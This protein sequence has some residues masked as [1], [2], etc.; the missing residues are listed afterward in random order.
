MLKLYDYFRS[1]CAY[2]VR[3]ALNIKAVEYETISI[4]LL[5]GKHKAQDY[6]KVNPQGLVPALQIDDTTLLTQ[7][8]AILDWINERYEVPPLFSQDINIRAAQRSVCSLIA[9]DI[10]PL[11]NLRVL[12]YLS[13][14]LSVNEADKKIWYQHWVQSAFQVIEEAIKEGPFSFGKTVSMVDIYLVPQVYNALRFDCDMSSFSNIMRVYERCNS[15]PEFE[16][17]HPDNA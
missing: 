15:R 9:C 10:H 14:E 5:N 11:N 4:N 2:R 16:H 8:T 12:K 13:H 17:A 6:I 7:S 3:I 1:S